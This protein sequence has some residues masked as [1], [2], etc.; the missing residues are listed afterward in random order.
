MNRSPGTVAAR[1]HEWPKALPCSRTGFTLVELLV[2]LGIIGQLAGLLLPAL[3][4]ARAKARAITCPSQ[5][6]R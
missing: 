4:Q 2:V 5:V 6:R 1:A 3:A